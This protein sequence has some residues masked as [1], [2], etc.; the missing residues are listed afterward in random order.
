MAYNV[1]ATQIIDGS[2][3]IVNAGNYTGAG[4]VTIASGGTSNSLTLNTAGTG[5]IILDTGTAG[6]TVQLRGGVSG[7]RI[8]NAAN[9]QFAQINVEALT[10]NR[11]VTFADANT[12]LVGGT[13]VSTSA[14]QTLTGA[15]TINNLVVPDTQ[16]NN[17]WIRNASPTVHLR[18]TNHNTSFLHCNSNLFYVLRGDTDAT[19]WTQVNGQW[20]LIVNLTN[21]NV[22]CGGNFTAV[23]NVTAYS[24]DKRLK[25]N[26][27]HIDFPIE[28]IKKLNGCTF[29]W[30]EGIK[31]LGFTPDRKTND[32]GLIAQEVQ[33][34]LPQAVVPAPFDQEWDNDNNSYKSKSGN[35]YL[36]VQYERLVPLLVE[37]IK[38][39]QEQIDI[40]NS[41]LSKLLK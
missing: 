5:S 11:T 2:R 38:N 6:G 24:S 41:K 1:G 8:Y 15:T 27:K 3:N 29:D 26:F 32:I 4:A 14:T 25:T 31:E 18:D 35:N 21:N 7:T 36:T 17:F 28:K 37:A 40:I 9:T 33:D 20:P 22:T 13:M 30:I 34:V 23:G 10:A 12:T 16:P 39:Q 19:T